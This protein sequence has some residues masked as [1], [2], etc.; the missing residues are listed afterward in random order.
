MSGNS[1][2]MIGGLLLAAAA[3]GG[4]FLAYKS[5]SFGALGFVPQSLSP[6]KDRAQRWLESQLKRGQH[7]DIPRAE[8]MDDGLAMESGK[9]AELANV[10]RR[11]RGGTKFE[12]VRSYGIGRPE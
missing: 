12:H 5:G 4:A 9:A 10:V 6:D 1:N 8:V 7:H 11:M 3:A 2:K